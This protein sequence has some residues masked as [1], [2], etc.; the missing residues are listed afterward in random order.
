MANAH[1]PHSLPPQGDRA[2]KSVLPRGIERWDQHWP[3]G[4]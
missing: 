2:Q 4:L 1:F 3:R